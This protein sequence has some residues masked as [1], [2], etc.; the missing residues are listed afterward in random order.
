MRKHARGSIHRPALGTAWC[1]ACR[2]MEK[3]TFSDPQVQQELNKGLFLQ[4][5]MTENTQAHRT[6]LRHFHL[7]AP[8]AFLVIKAPNYY[9]N[10]LIGS[11]SA[12]E[13]LNWLKKEKNF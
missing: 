7:Y 9:G 13:F 12:K 10:S 11:K 2:E 1:Q 5:D 8:P 4:L 6:F 3:Y